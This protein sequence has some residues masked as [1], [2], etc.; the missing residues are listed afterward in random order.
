MVEIILLLDIYQTV[1]NS[2]LMIKSMLDKKLGD[3]NL[4]KTNSVSQMKLEHF[5]RSIKE[6]CLE[7]NEEKAVAPQDDNRRNQSSSSLRNQEKFKE[8]FDSF[9]KSLI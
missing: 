4:G 3:L 8:S 6:E 9:Q 1:K 5:L 2:K 7:E